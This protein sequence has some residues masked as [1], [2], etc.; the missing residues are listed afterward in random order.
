MT[1]DFAAKTRMLHA[2][3]TACLSSE[4]LSRVEDFLREFHDE[5]QSAIKLPHPYEIK[6]VHADVGRAWETG[7]R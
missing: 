7:K 4:D 6:E 2:K 5:A 1:I 3:I